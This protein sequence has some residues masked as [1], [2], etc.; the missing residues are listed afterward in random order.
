MCNIANMCILRNKTSILQ[1]EVKILFNTDAAYQSYLL[2]YQFSH[3]S[4]DKVT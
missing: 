4:H 2:I 3:F 1:F